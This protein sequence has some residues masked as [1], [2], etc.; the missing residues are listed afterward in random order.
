M[1][2]IRVR[3]NSDNLIKVRLGADNANRVVSAVAN[4]KM[5]LTDLNDVNTTTAIPN[6]SVLVYNSST[7][8]WNPYP[9]I[10]GGTY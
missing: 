4:L 1:S 3:T 6:N 7:E 10:D 8:Q 9:F 2:D 5:N